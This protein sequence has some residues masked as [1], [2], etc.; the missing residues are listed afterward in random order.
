MNEIIFWEII[1]LFNWNEEGDDDAVIEPAVDKLAAMPV[2][3]I[4]QFSEILAEKLYLLD[5]MQYAKN[6][7]EFSYK[8]DDENFSGDHF[9]YVR[10]CVVANGKDYFYQVLEDPTTMPKDLDFEAML[11]V[12]AQAYCKKTGEEEYDYYDTKFSFE[13]FSNKEA[14]ST[15]KPK[16]KPKWKFW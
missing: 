5:G 2:E 8:N 12:P 7:G 14:W 15:E 4:N 6:I 9:L 1:A 3:D 10:C 11:E 16:T 13:T